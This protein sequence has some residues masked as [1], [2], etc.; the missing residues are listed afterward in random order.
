MALYCY[1]ISIYAYSDSEYKPIFHENKY[2]KKE[3]ENICKQ[4]QEKI[5]SHWSGWDYQRQFIEIAISEFG[6]KDLNILE[7]D[8]NDRKVREY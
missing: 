2:S 8:V 5:T 3:F 4:I 7:F 1:M 6:F